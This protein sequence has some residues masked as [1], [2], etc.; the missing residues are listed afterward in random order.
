MT[1]RSAPGGYRGQAGLTGTE[2]TAGGKHSLV[3]LGG[4]YGHGGHEIASTT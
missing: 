2:A 4:T 1:T 3:K